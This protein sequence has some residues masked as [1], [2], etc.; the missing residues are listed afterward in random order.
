MVVLALG[1]SKPFLPLRGAFYA[2]RLFPIKSSTCVEL[3]FVIVRIV[4]LG[5]LTFPVDLS[6]KEVF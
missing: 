1:V 5:L 4:L 3:D 6:L 2:R